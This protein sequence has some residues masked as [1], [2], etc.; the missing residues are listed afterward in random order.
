EQDPGSL[1]KPDG[2]I[3]LPRPL[4]D[5]EKPPFST[6]ISEKAPPAD[7]YHVGTAAFRH[8]ACADALRRASDFWGKILG[9]THKWNAA[10]KG[11]VL[12][13]ILDEGV[14]LNAYYDRKA[15][16]F[17]HASTGGRMIYSGESPD[18]VCHEHGHGAL[19]CFRPQ[20]W[21]AAAFEPPAFHESFAD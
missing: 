4:P 3:L 13:V 16:N 2:G 6:K 10:I 12:P 9:K 7:H 8:W 11:N 17:F 18:V 1:D 21:D 15:L 20:L 19:D 5:T 14:D